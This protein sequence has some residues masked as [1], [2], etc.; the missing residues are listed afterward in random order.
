[1]IVLAQ[2][3]HQEHITNIDDFIWRMCVSYRKLN[4]IKKPFQFPIPRCD[5]ATTVL[6][7][8]AGE[9]WIIS[10]DERQGY[11]QVTVRKID[12]D[13]LVF[14]HLLIANTVSM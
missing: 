7:W 4:G 1:M 12:Q 8:S 2:K 9:I 11:H 6:S 3:L 10:L 13:K 14:L 5:D